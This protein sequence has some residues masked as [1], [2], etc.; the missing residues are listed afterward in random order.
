[1]IRKPAG[2]YSSFAPV[3]TTMRSPILSRSAK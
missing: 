2:G 1:M 3:S